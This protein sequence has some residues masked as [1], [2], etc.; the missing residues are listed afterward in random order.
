MG[1][2]RHLDSIS[3]PVVL[4]V[5][6]FALDYGLLARLARERTAR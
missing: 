5:I 1:D 4:F 2:R 3:T 6:A